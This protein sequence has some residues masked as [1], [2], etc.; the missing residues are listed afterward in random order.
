[1]RGDYGLSARLAAVAEMVPVGSSVADV[2]TDHGLL[3]IGLVGTGRASS[4]IG[5][6]LAQDALEGAR[7]NRARF[8][9]H[10]DLRRSDG[11]AELD[12]GEATVLVLAGVGGRTVARILS[13][14]DPR[15][16]G[17]DRIIV[18]PNTGAEEVRR[19]LASL[20]YLVAEERLVPDGDRFFLVLAADLGEPK[21][22]SLKEAFVG[23]LRSDPLFPEWAEQQRRHLS[24]K[25][26]SSEVDARLA[27]LH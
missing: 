7:A 19:A 5:L 17:I 6:D 4:G 12:P 20:G 21:A 24:K 10:V 8:G 26:P 13:G 1:M 27:L 18:Q 22:L 25:P 3:L 14:R 23:G 11:L 16:L 2:G 15:P 9:V